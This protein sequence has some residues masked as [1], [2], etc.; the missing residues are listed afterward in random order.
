MRRFFILAAGLSLLCGCSHH[1]QLELSKK[2]RLVSEL[3]SSAPECAGFKT[4][5]TNPSTDD[6]AVDTIFHEALTAHCV[7]KDV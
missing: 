6:D 3:I 5:L 2:E 1:R 7:Q 4:K